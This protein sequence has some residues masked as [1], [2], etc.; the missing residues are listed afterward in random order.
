MPQT[1]QII[2]CT[3]PDQRSAEKIAHLLVN[4]GLAACINIVPSIASVYKWQGQIETTQEHLL[5]IKSKKENYPDLE[6][7]IKAHHPYEVPEII[8]I[9]IEDGL[10]EYLKWI[11][12][13]LSTT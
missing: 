4:S 10:P 7:S 1:I 5:L 11:D 8:A 3:C 9:A 6:T 2:L 13:C 12:S